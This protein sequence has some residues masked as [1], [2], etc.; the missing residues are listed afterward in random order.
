MKIL[1]LG[2]SYTSWKWP[3]WPDYLQ[4]LLGPEHE[5]VNCGQKGDSNFIIAHKL[6][7]L[8]KHYHWDKVFVMWTGSTR[9][10]LIID[11][12]NKQKVANLQNCPDLEVWEKIYA[13][14]LGDQLYV[15]INELK[16]E[17]KDFFPAYGTL[18]HHIKSDY[19]IGRAHV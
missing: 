8:L 3:T 7:Y 12:T 6:N 10:S 9:E 11:D 13:N 4:Q 15:N 16:H 1:T 5:V 18:D 17:F 14:K 19:E 2:C